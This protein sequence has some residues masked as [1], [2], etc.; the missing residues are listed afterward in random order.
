MFN[1]EKRYRNKIIIIIIIITLDVL[2][3]TV[4]R[5]LR[6]EQRNR[7]LFEVLCLIKVS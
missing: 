1:M 6:D 4:P 5:E 7:I 2:C 3:R